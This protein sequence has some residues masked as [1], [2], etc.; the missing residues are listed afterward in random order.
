[1][2]ASSAFLAANAKLNKQPVWLLQIQDYHY[3]FSNY[4]L[5]TFSTPLG[6]PVYESTTSD[7]SAFV[8]N[9]DTSSGYGAA[10]VTGKSSG[11]MERWQSA[12]LVGYHAPGYL[13]FSSLIGLYAAPGSD[14]PGLRPRTSISK[15]YAMLTVN[16]AADPTGWSPIWGADYSTDG[17]VT[18]TTFASTSTPGD[19]DWQVDITSALGSL[20]TYDFNNLQIRTTCGSSIS[21]SG[22]APGSVMLISSVSVEFEFDDTTITATA[23]PW[24]VNI[25]D[26][27]LTVSDLDGGFDLA[28]LT[29][30]V[31]D[32]Q[33]KLTADMG[34]PA[35]FIFEG[36]KC[37]LLHGFVGMALSD[38]L[39]MFVGVINT[40]S[41]DNTNQEYKFDVSSF[42]LKKLTAAI[43]TTGDDGFTT[44]SKHT[45]TV[46]GHPLD[47]L[48]SAL[49]QAGVLAAN[50]NTVKIN[51]YK[52]T[53][54]SGLEFA[55][56]LTK[57]PIAKDF[58]ESELMKP[59][60]MYLW[61]NANGLVSVNSFY[62][63]LSGDGTY[64][65]PTI[66]VMTLDQ[67]SCTDIPLVTE[68][69]LIDQ[70]E[71]RFDDDGTGSS[72]FLSD[73]L[74]YYDASVNKYGLTD[75]H[76]IE[77]TGLRSAF[78]GYLIAGFVSR[79]IFL[80]YGSK[81]IVVDPQTLLWN[82]CLLEP[83]DIIALD[84]PY[85]PDRPAGVLG[86]TGQTFE[87]LDRTFQ[88]MKGNVQVR[89]LQI[90]I[91][92][93][94]QYLITTNGEADYTAASSGDKAT[95]M[96]LSGSDGKYSNG[97]PGNTLG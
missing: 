38:Y 76:I 41:S 36:K 8:A 24:L 33:Q 53:I 9:S 49:E 67:D 86:F 71:M 25:D 92:N 22:T 55:F 57:A 23:E 26:Q 95:L 44:S 16:I 1:M 14:A 35:N 56:T 97:D 21:H 68:A 63:A 88:Y 48:V 15:V 72:K 18:W 19:Y 62:P 6:E 52:N 70:V 96:F 37:V 17:G 4:S 78:Q 7:A 39:T 51:F 61:E 89:L 13:V 93:F 34:S 81:N 94:K 65:P 58:I 42:N 2:N 45:K 69:D 85:L 83:G 10:A 80:R 60:G 11:W 12:T 30:N 50:I 5:G 43:Y 84:S 47:M 64:I 82:A 59:L 29:F 3:G 20:S 66:P 46:D 75:S 40:V 74:A 28:D 91:K 87:V 27:K 79:L 90:N 32:Y 54:F 31:L 73:S 77:S